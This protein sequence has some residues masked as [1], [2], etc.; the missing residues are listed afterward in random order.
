M[1]NS[2][3]TYITSTYNSTPKT[4]N[5]IESGQK[6]WIDIFPNR[7]G[8]GA[9]KD[10]Q[11]RICDHRGNANPDRNEMSPHN[12]QNAIIRNTTSHKCR[13]GCGEREPSSAVGGNVMGAATMDSHAKVS[14]RTRNRTSMWLSTATPGQYLKVT[15]T[16]ILKD[17]CTPAFRLRLWLSWWGVRLECGRP[18]LG[19]SLEEGKGYPLRYS[20][21]EDSTD[22][23]VLGVAK[24]QTWL[25]DL[26]CHFPLVH[27]SIIYDRQ[28]VETA[29]STNREWLKK[30]EY[31]SA[32]KNETFPFARTRMDLESVTLSR[33]RQGEKGK[34]RMAPHV[35]GI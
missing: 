12:A 5:L 34:Y 17:T 31:Y 13:W 18:E 20:D 11:Y 14:C 35:C 6:S 3:S 2:R 21:P 8:R 1:T 33:I 23:I 19:R 29:E 24:S 26:H 9:R 15:K 32:T 27:R 16:L 10:G 30:M 28:G 22:C 7:K 25:R 4:N